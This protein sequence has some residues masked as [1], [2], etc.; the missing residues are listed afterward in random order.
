MTS[1]ETILLDGDLTLWLTLNHNMGD[2][3][4]EVNL[5]IAFRERECLLRY[6]DLYS[7]VSNRLAELLRRL[8]VNVKR[9]NVPSDEVRKLAASLQSEN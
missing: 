2:F 7:I 3:K 5:R 4:Y 9:L 8:E 1:D 6:E